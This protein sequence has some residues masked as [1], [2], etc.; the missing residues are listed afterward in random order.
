MSHLNDNGICKRHASKPSPHHIANTL[1]NIVM[2]AKSR[3][4][5][6]KSAGFI[7]LY[8]QATAIQTVQYGIM[9][10][11]VCWFGL[12]QLILWIQIFHQNPMIVHIRSNA[13]K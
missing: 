13:M 1:F 7:I 12:R 4:D 9:D 2:D 11:V 10:V 8:I 6:S 3:Y 5:E